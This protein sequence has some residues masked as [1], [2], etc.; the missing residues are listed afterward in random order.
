MADDPVERASVLLDRA[1]SQP[2]TL[3]PRAFDDLLAS[4]NPQARRYAIDGLQRLAAGEPAVL[5]ARVERI[6]DLLTDPDQGV[7]AGATDAFAEGVDPAAVVERT[8]TLVELLDDDFPVVRSNALEALVRAAHENPGTCRAFVDDIVPLLDADTDHVRK[9]A[10]TFLAAVAEEYP[11]AV[12]PATDRLFDVFRSALDNEIGV[13]PAMRRD[14]SAVQSHVE[15]L[16]DE[17]IGRQRDLRRIA[18]H[19]I[20]ELTRADPSAVVPEVDAVVALLD[21]P[22]PEIRSVALGVLSALATEHPERVVEHADAIAALLDD[23]EGRMVRAGACRALASVCADEPDAVA[24]AVAD[25]VGALRPLLGHD[26]APVRRS[27]AHLSVLIADRAGDTATSEPG[28]PR[29]DGVGSAHGTA[30]DAP[31]R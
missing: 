14:P 16:V 20:Y 30:A 31:D 22:D 15:H 17:V 26:E 7:R 28:D 25:R 12:V 3:D 23:H 24:A 27:A 21:D 29:D 11:E 19:A 2:D 18:G 9:H 4:E 8:A 6:A 10:V 13:E 1:R 5:N